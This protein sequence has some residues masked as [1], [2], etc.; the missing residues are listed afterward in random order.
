MTLDMEHTEFACLHERSPEWL[1]EEADRVLNHWRKIRSK[2]PPDLA[3]TACRL[4]EELLLH[5]FA[6]VASSTSYHPTWTFVTHVCRDWRYIAL[7]CPSLWSHIVPYSQS[8]A[9]TCLERAGSLPLRLQ[10]DDVHR[11]PQLSY[12]DIAPYISRISHMSMKCPFS[13]HSRFSDYFHSAKPWSS[14]ESLTLAVDADNEL[15]PVVITFDSIAKYPPQNLQLLLLDGLSPTSWPLN[16]ALY[17][18]LRTLH[19]R[20]LTEDNDNFPSMSIFL[21]VLDMCLQLE[22]LILIRA[23]P[24]VSASEDLI[25]PHSLGTRMVQMS[26]L[27]SLVLACDEGEDIRYLLSHLVISESTCLDLHCKNYEHLSDDIEIGGVMS[28]LPSDRSNLRFFR[29]ISS[30][31]VR[32]K[33]RQIIVSGTRAHETSPSFK[34]ALTTV[35]DF[36]EEE[37][38]CTVLFQLGLIF[39]LTAL[40]VNLPIDIIQSIDDWHR[41]L[42]STPLL[43]TINVLFQRRTTA[44]LDEMEDFDS[45][46]RRLLLA[47]TVAPSSVAPSIAPHLTSLHLSQVSRR[48]VSSHMSDIRECVY[49]R[50][51]RLPD[52]SSF[53]LVINGRLWRVS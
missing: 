17:L 19:L 22:D 49:S 37:A 5:I 12:G 31:D 45:P 52:P 20:R 32:G 16:P 50:M 24:T 25:E 48:H 51:T 9:S 43:T 26:R 29:T 46:L 10:W 11:E 28:C 3:A 6:Y 27:R 42:S 39:P 18:H 1:L 2:L 4:P 15:V 14:L 7:N 30:V 47:L 36:I 23:S 35:Y 8:Y 53:Q 34:L 13:D 41:T 21:D 38:V 40:S 33:N 44:D